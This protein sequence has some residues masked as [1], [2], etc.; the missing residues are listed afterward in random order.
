GSHCLVAP[1]STSAEWKTQLLVRRL[2]INSRIGIQA[3][4]DA[5][6][7]P[8]RG[9]NLSPLTTLAS[10][11][12]PLTAPKDLTLGVR[13]E[14]SMRDPAIGLFGV[15][16]KRW[17]QSSETDRRRPASKEENCI[18]GSNEN[19]AVLERSHLYCGRTRHARDR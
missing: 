6:V 18:E 16:H 8:S 1:C 13:N 19:V 2:L 11:T 14:N 17:D 9:E 5:M 3:A 4:C 12:F 15:E 10:Q 7:A